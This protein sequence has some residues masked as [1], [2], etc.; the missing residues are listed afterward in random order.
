MRLLTIWLCL[1]ATTAAQA[2][3]PCA[4]CNAAPAPMVGAGIPAMLVVGGV[5]FGA[6]L[7]KHWRRS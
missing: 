3:P 1:G 5:L 7:L 6:T 4:V 2:V